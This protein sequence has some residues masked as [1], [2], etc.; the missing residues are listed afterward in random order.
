MRAKVNRAR[1][2]GRGWGGGISM[3]AA[4]RVVCRAP[5]PF[6][7]SF[8]F[9]RQGVP[10]AATPGAGTWSPMTERCLSTSQWAKKRMRRLKR[11]RRRQRAK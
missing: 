6:W 7:H 2:R 3:G 10:N 9:H 11:K 4:I 8:A 5:G 1:G